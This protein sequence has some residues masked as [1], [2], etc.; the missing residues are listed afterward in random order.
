MFI[1]C[2]KRDGEMYLDAKFVGPFPTWDALGE[3]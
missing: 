3:R 1:I 2:F